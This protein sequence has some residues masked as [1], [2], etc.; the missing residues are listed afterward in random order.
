MGALGYTLRIEAMFENE[1]NNEASM[2]FNVAAKLKKAVAFKNN[3][4]YE[5]ALTAIDEALKL[6]ENNLDA[7]LMKGVMLGKFGRCSEVLKC[8]DRI[9]ELDPKCANAW[10]LK[11]EIGRA[12]V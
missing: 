3:G 12:H 4:K 1:I 11:G 6:Q 9:I 10:H 2:D 8:F 7:W 5:S